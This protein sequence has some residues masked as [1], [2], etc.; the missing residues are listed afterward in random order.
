MKPTKFILCHC[1]YKIQLKQILKALEEE[2]TL[3]SASKDPSKLDSQYCPLLC[4]KQ[5][6]IWQ[7]F[8]R[9]AVK[10]IE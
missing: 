6:T 10:Y 4:L 5:K 7:R 3:K 8:P 9:V 2:K 1:T